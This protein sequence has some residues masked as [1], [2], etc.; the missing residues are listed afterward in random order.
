M[1]TFVFSFY[2]EI[3]HLGVVAN[4]ANEDIE[5]QVGKLAYDPFAV[6]VIL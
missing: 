2:L 6:T 3:I 5:S 1:L 4:T